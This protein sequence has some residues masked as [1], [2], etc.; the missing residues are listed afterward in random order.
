MDLALFDFD[1]TITRKDSLPDFVQ[2]A[3]GSPRYYLGLFVLSPWLVAFKLGLLSNERTKQR[4]LAHFFAG[5]ERERFQEVADAYSRERIDSIT[6]ASAMAA[7]ASHRERGD[8]VVVVSASMES[9]LRAWC[10]QHDLE[11][12]ATRLEF[13]DGKLT[14]GFATRNCHGA[15]KLNRVRERFDLDV[16]EA[17][18][19]YGDSRGDRAMLDIADHAH[20]RSFG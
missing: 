20:Y 10:A 3:V 5:W 18:H 9:W 4:L 19:A 17:I 8:R 1:G 12:I 15:E 6:R 13:R 16:F 2:F 11:L 7:I 14:G